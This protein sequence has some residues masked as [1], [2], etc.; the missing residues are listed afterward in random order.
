MSG[1]KL[2]KM[3]YHVTVTKQHL[4]RQLTTTQ[5]NVVLSNIAT[6]GLKAPAA[7]CPVFVP[8]DCGSSL[9]P[10]SCVLVIPSE[11][12]IAKGCNRNY[13]IGPFV[14]RGVANENFV[15][16][17]EP[18]PLETPEGLVVSPEGGVELSPE[19]VLDDKKIKSMKVV[20][21]RVALQARGVSKNRLNEVL[22]G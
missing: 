22:I 4:P 17:D 18:P 3:N 14:E 1:V 5:H 16:M 9:A 6:E 13:Q 8:I 19:P 10:P 21:L 20:E 15:S 7:A 2:R 11:E 12:L